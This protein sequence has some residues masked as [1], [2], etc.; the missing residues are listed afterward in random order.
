IVD[1]F[2]DTGLGRESFSIIGQGKIDEIL[3]SK[4]EDRRAVFEEAA[5]VLK[6]KKRKRKAEFKLM[7]TNDNLDRVKD[8]IHEI[9]QQMDPL[10]EQADKAEKYQTYEARL[11]KVDIAL[12]VTEIDFLHKEWQ[13]KTKQLEESQLTEVNIR[14]NIQQ[15][16]AMLTKHRQE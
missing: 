2:M 4:A 1:L 11:Q 7:E 10:K 9:K 15:K 16:E 6:Y 5:G 13:T 12:L 8:I 14:T 3:S